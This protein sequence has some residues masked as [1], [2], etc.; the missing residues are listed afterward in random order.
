MNLFKK[1]AAAVALVALLSGIFSTGVSAYSTA[2]VEAANYLAS[3]GIIVSHTDN[4]AA[5][6]LDQNV[7]RQ[8]IAAVARGI[9]G[10]DKSTSYKGIFKDVTETTPNNWAWASV[11]PL[12]ENGLIALNENFNPERNISK[13]EA[14]GMVVKATFGDQYTYNAALGTTWQQQVVAFALTNGVITSNFTNYDTPATRG[15]AFEA[16]ANAKRAVGETGMED[17]IC[18]LLGICEDTGTS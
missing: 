11:E 3:E 10:L 8:E 4:P 9:A 16:G 6:N 14:I 2:E 15:F 12:A 13:A 1:I 17:I 18:Q 7:L 5:Y